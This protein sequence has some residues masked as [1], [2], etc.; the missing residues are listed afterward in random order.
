[1]DLKQLQYFVTSV[2]CGSF[3]GASQMLYTSQPHIS[4][5]VKSLESELQI[6]LL[7]RKARGVEVTEEGKKVY[8]YA[9]RILE[10]SRELLK[11]H[12]SK[13]MLKKEREQ[14][15][16]F[17]GM[18]PGEKRRGFLMAAEGDP[19]LPATCICGR[20]KGPSVLITGGIHNAEYVGIQAAVELSEELDA[21]QISGRIYLLPL[22]NRSGFEHR[23][24]SLVHEDGTNLNR[25][26]P[27][28]ED[29]TLGQRICHMLVQKLFTEID[30]YIDLHSGD[31]FEE[32]IPHVYTL[33]AAAPEVNAVSEEMARCVDVPYMYASLNPSGG[34]YNHAGSMGVPGILLERGC[35]SLWSREEVEQDKED[36]K[37]ILRYLKILQGP[38]NRS[39]RCPEKMSAWY[40]HTAEHTGLWYPE[41]KAG[42][43]VRKGELLGTIKDYF[44]K[45]LESCHAEA[46]GILLYQTISLNIIKGDPLAAYGT[47]HK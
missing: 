42:D 14:E 13:L 17:R 40:G 37:N 30:Y 20:H 44:G 1:M 3:K 32:L 15:L 2:D 43:P 46:D 38:V 5:T 35:K 27:G 7:R 21:E 45:A 28:S 9:R 6:Q 47:L 33:G 31:G 19:E 8:Q 11:I 24:M 4:K 39:H 10:E 12:E 29:G 26:F 18:H 41:K 36:V 34:A 16:D 25:I 22:V 23:T